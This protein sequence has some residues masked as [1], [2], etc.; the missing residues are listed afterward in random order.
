MISRNTI[1]N[2]RTHVD[3]VASYDPGVSGGATA[4][5]VLIPDIIISTDV[6]WNGLKHAKL[7]P[8]LKQLQHSIVHATAKGASY[9][10]HNSTIGVVSVAKVTKMLMGLNLEEFCKDVV[11][12]MVEN[13]DQKS[14]AK[15][16][17]KAISDSSLGA[18]QLVQQLTVALLCSGHT[19]HAALVTNA[20]VE[21]CR[22]HEW[23]ISAKKIA[24]Y[25]APAVVLAVDCNHGDAVAFVQKKMIDDGHFD[26]VTQ[27]ILYIASEGGRPDIVARGTLD[28][29]QCLR[30]DD[31]GINM[32]SSVA[33][34]AF[35][36]G[37]CDGNETRVMAH[38]ACEM[39]EE[40]RSN[41]SL[42]EDACKTIALAAIKG[43]E[44]YQ[45]P[46][47]VVKVS[48][49]MWREDHGHAISRA[50]RHMAKLKMSHAMA[51]ITI[52]AIRHGYMRVTAWLILDMVRCGYWYTLVYSMYAC[53]VCLVWGSNAASKSR[54]QSHPIQLK[55]LG[56]Q[57]KHTSRTIR[58]TRE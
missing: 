12:A 22:R 37:H 28:A 35:C 19:Q 47:R 3:V 29:I 8:F 24:E 44:I 7:D 40:S 17:H 56:R 31:Q 55:T 49:T 34:G 42:R 48:H 30:K 26:I 21:E 10:I 32:A 23:N 20:F 38:V 11:V 33:A 53:I 27:L 9:T 13:H 2:P 45:K 18:E 5:P 4:F 50:F 41:L 51:M 15:V 52:K 58:N 46:L 54:P 1:E 36:S 57:E 39:Y 14:V 6:D 16:Q 25:I 43:V